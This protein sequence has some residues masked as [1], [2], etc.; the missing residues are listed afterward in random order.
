M[1]KGNSKSFIPYF[2]GFI[3]VLNIGAYFI[4]RKKDGPQDNAGGFN[5]AA[6]KS[7]PAHTGNGSLEDP[8]DYNE[9]APYGRSIK[10]ID[11]FDPEYV[12]GVSP[13]LPYS[14]FVPDSE[15]VLDKV[16]NLFDGGNPDL[17][18][19]EE[20]RDEHVGPWDNY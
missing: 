19:V 14:Q 17:T 13:F 6:G 16:I 10:S 11:E 4:L 9:P 1:E 7:I 2:L 20:E 12:A 5:M 3:V 18:E 8:I 15:S